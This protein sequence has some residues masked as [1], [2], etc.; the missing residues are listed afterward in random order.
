LTSLIL[1]TF[2]RQESGFKTYALILLIW[3]IHQEAQLIVVKI[4][5]LKKL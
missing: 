5:E 1:K 3:S 4:R 2:I